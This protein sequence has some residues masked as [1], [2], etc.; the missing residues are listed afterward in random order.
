LQTRLLAGTGTIQM[1]SQQPQSQ[2]KPNRRP[3]KTESSTEKLFK[4]QII[5]TC[6]TGEAL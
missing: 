3:G 5:Q 2:N 1:P 6:R 4:Q